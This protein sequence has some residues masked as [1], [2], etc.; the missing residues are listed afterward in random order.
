MLGPN[1]CL[2]GPVFT[3]VLPKI[4]VEALA[5]C[6]N[7]EPPPLRLVCL[8]VRTVGGLLMVAGGGVWLLVD[9]VTAP[10]VAETVGTTAAPIVGG[11]FVT[12]NCDVRLP[13]IE[14]FSSSA[15][16][17]LLSR[18]VASEFTSKPAEVTDDGGGSTCAAH[19]F[20]MKRPLKTLNLF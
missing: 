3:G 1:I 20:S 14:G 4:P 13:S 9:C 7:D 12:S 2:E 19:C 11:F 16:E 18:L 8:L 6:G 10:T 15:I 17:S 5:C